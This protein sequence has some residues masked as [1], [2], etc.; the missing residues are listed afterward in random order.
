MFK[1]AVISENAKIFGVLKTLGTSENPKSL[2]GLA[3]LKSS[4]NKDLDP[5]ALIGAV[6]VTNQTGFDLMDSETGAVGN[7]IVKGKLR[8]P[9]HKTV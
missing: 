3:A 5:D 8:R 1:N 7:P 9:D 6:I 2:K 4:L